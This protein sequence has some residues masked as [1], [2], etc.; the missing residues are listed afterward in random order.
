MD[1]S[2]V[3]SL[4]FVKEKQKKGTFSPKTP[5]LQSTS[6]KSERLKTKMTR[7]QSVVVLSLCFIV[8][9]VAAAADTEEEPR[10]FEKPAKG[11]VR[12]TETE[13]YE[14][15]GRHPFVLVLYDAP[16]CPACTRVAN[17][18][19][20]LEARL[21]ARDVALVR[22]NALAYPAVRRRDGVQTIPLLRLYTEGI[23]QDYD[24]APDAAAV[25]AFVEAGLEPPFA[26][27]RTAPALA[28]ART[29]ARFTVAACLN[30]DAGHDD[31][32]EV[33][34][35]VARQ[36]RRH[37][38]TQ[39][40]AVPRALAP[41]GTVCPD[42]WLLHD[43][44]PEPIVF[45][46]SSVASRLEDEAKNMDEDSSKNEDK[47]K[48]KDKKEKDKDKNKKTPIQKGTKPHRDADSIS[49]YVKS[50]CARALTTWV[51]TRA[52]P[53]YDEITSD[54]AAT[55]L[56]SALPIVWTVIDSTSPASSS[57]TVANV[58]DAM[59]RAAREHLGSLTFVR[60]DRAA[61]PEQ[62]RDL[63]VAEGPVPAMVVSDRLKYVCPA[64]GAQLTEAR[65]RTFLAQYLAHALRPQLSSEPEPDAAA[66]RAHAVAKV[67]GTS[68]AR[69]VR[70]PA[71]DVFVLYYTDWCPHC[72]EF[73]PTWETVARTLRP[74]RA[75]LT[76]AAYNWAL[77]EVETD[78][79]IHGFPALL[80][81]PA[82][83]KD[84]PVTYTGD[85]SEKD[86]YE[87]IVLRRSRAWP[88]PKRAMDLAFAVPDEPEDVFFGENEKP[89]V[90]RVAVGGGN[91][92]NDPRAELKFE[93]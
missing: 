57:K 26:A 13:L 14:Q 5:K 33:F 25:A 48:N 29:R 83:D 62:A 52:V 41:P 89:R 54:N 51:R 19:H 92:I 67:V 80:F 71:R 53:L 35:V 50:G 49:S 28:E 75:H 1:E 73:L 30:E 43:E 6:P 64:A 86:L 78:I 46:Y 72:K 23:A 3:P 87:F 81:Y 68:W 84:H 77:N 55:Y 91:G 16:S 2:F 63:G 17:V 60:L 15:I 18:L 27:V 9:L 24:G 34:Y 69:V 74:A 45:G 61:H 39:F 59:R 44:V 93:L 42:V 47:N 32:Q 90:K 66:V 85:M 10:L 56:E 38:A 37:R 65:V 82:G 8:A 58:E 79:R 11:L 21:Y 76:V 36:L 40:V 70:D 22:I 12:V 20:M 4:F 7:I 31:A 88:L